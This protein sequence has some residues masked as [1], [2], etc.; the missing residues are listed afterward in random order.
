VVEGQEEALKGE[1]MVFIRASRLRWEKVADYLCEIVQYILE[2]DSLYMEYEPVLVWHATLCQTM[3][4]PTVPILAQS[5]YDVV[6]SMRFEEDPEFEFAV[7]HLSRWMKPFESLENIEDSVFQ[8]LYWMR[9][10]I[11]GYR[12]L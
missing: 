1:G 2:V 8:V 11:E 7:N 9:A 12:S 10:G 6:I 4:H 5:L 3:E